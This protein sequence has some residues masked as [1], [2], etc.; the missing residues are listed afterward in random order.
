MADYGP[1]RSITEAM[2][3]R[4]HQWTL[5]A[6][7]PRLRAALSAHTLE[8]SDVNERTFRQR[9]RA[10]SATRPQPPRTDDVAHVKRL[11]PRGTNGLDPRYAGLDGEPIAPVEARA[12]P[13]GRRY[14]RA[15]GESVGL[16]MDDIDRCF[17]DAFHKKYGEFATRPSNFVADIFGAQHDTKCREPQVWRASGPH[18]E[19][20]VRRFPNALPT[21]RTN[22]VDDIHG[23]QPARSRAPKPVRAYNSARAAE[24]QASLEFP[25]PRESQTLTVV[26]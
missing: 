9:F 13:G 4:E 19:P 2:A 22:R 18:V 25:K 14:V 16:R 11:P 6:A 20:G 5:P 21:K 1:P 3:T 15:P 23:A 12:V 10:I 7:E 8:Y 24:V 17:A 26:H